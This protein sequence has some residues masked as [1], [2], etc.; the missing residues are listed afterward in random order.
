MNLFAFFKKKRENIADIQE[1][2]NQV[3]QTLDNLIGVQE[4]EDTEDVD[5]KNENLTLESISKET[6]DLCILRFAENELKKELF[7]DHFFSNYYPSFNLEDIDPLFGDAARL[8]VVHQQ[9]STSLVQRKFTIGYNRAGRLM[10]QLQSAGIVGA[11]E[12]FKARQVLIP[13]ENHLDQLLKSIKEGTYIPSFPYNLNQDL[14][15]EIRIK[16]IDSIN[17]KKNE[18]KNK[19]YLEKKQ[20]EEAEIEHQKEIIRLEIIEN[21]KK[22]QLR[23][24][25]KK[26]LIESGHIQQGRKR[27]SIPQDV[28]DKVWIRDGGKCVICGSCENLEFDHIIPFSKGGAST[29]R[30]VQLLCEKCNREKSNKIG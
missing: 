8:I 29:Y 24:Q 3:D 7:D 9:G 6:I 1:Q 25:V 17:L 26:E 22:R 21:E 19:F 20:A 11:F 10:D 12:G 30:N 28:Q 18:L 5:L 4:I 2:N 16:Y 14:K 23:R 27:E 13:N 15:E